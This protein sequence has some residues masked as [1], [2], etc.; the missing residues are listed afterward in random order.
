LKRWP[1]NG[2][3]LHGLAQALRQQNSDE[4]PAV[5]ARFEKAWAEADI[6]MRASCM[7]VIRRSGSAEKS[8]KVTD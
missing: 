6:P 3:S 8:P 7:C 1:E 5:Q 4:A 2:W